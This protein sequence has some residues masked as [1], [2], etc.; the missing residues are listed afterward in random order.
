MQFMNPRKF[1]TLRKISE[2]ILKITVVSKARE[3]K[4]LPHSCQIIILGANQKKAKGEEVQSL[5]NP[6]LVPS[7]S[8]K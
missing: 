6:H 1:C 7:E 8:K 2:I 3:M 4:N 5:N